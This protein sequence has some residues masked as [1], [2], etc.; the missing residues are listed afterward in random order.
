[1]K[2]KYEITINHKLT[3]YKSDTYPNCDLFLFCVGGYTWAY[4]GSKDE[5][6]LELNGMA[7]RQSIIFSPAALERSE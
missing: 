2:Y 3:T 5:V 6:S 7:Q 4:T 1:M